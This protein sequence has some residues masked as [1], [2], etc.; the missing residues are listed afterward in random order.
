[1]IDDGSFLMKQERGKYRLLWSG[2]LRWEGIEPGAATV[3]FMVFSED[4][5]WVEKL[6]TSISAIREL[7]RSKELEQ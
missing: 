7:V 5:P 4:N 3:P 2:A 6:D 1:M